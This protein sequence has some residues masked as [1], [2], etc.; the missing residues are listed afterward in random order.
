MSKRMQKWL[1]NRKK[2]GA[3][4]PSSLTPHPMVQEGKLGL[5][6]AIPLLVGLFA[7]LYIGKTYYITEMEFSLMLG[8]LLGLWIC[9]LLT[10][11]AWA[12]ASATEYFLFDREFGFTE[13]LHPRYEVYSKPHQILKMLGPEDKIEK[14]NVLEKRLDDF[15]LPKEIK[16]KIKEMITKGKAFKKYLYY[17]RHKDVFEGWDAEKN[18]RPYFQSHLVFM[19]KKFDEQFVFG[20]GQENWYGPIMYNHPHAESDSIKVLGWAL[21]PFSNEPMP[22][23]ILLHSSKT[24]M[25]KNPNPKSKSDFKL[26][27]ALFMIIASQ[28]G[29][30]DSQRKKESHLTVLKDSKLHDVKNIIKYGHDIA[31]AD[32]K[33]EE[34]IMK[35]VSRKILGSMWFKVLVSIVS[36]IAIVLIIGIVFFGLDLGAIF[37]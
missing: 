17:F 29:I 15:K 6:I 25:K 16:G 23:C 36:I 3:I 5:V 9:F 20:Q 8:A 11:Y 14:P 30:I 26:H 24:Y 1:R 13:R 10:V 18:E 7:I 4:E 2:Q 12:K 22:V 19:D 28:H 37:R 21:D 32:R 31:D 35:P 33:L 34:E 27:D